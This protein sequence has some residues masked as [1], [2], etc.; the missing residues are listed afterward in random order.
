MADDPKHTPSWHSERYYKNHPEAR[1]TPREESTLEPVPRKPLRHRLLDFSEHPLF[2]TSIGVLGGIVG[3]LLYAPVLVVCGICV[4]LAFHRARVVAGMSVHRVQAPAYVLLGAIV[5]GSLYG[6]HVVIG[7]ELKEANRSLAKYLVSYMK[8]TAANVIMSKVE[9]AI[10]QTQT[11][12]RVLVE[13][14][15]PIGLN[16]HYVNIGQEKAENNKGFAR[17]Y[18]IPANSPNILHSLVEQFV[19][20]SQM[21]MDIHSGVGLPTGGADDFWFSGLLDRKIELDDIPKLR[22]SSE[23]IYIFATETFSDSTGSHYLHYC[24]AVQPPP[25][26]MD[27]N[28]DVLHY[29]REYVDSR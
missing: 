7:S 3:L 13:V 23:V 8:P 29:C 11:R 2:T 24:R 28:L 6:L 26:G 1:P 9:S 17:I 5:F 27:F 14:G 15:K 18:I 21:D 19:K 4:M 20:E 16:F 25:A 22:A 10:V 12:Q